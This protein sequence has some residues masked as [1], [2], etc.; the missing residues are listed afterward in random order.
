MKKVA[1]T[2]IGCRLN[3]YE[4]E[5]LAHQLTSIGLARV[6]FESGA[7]L[8]IINTCTVT[9][10]ADA[11]CRRAIARAGKYG[12]AKVV[13]VGCYVTADPDKVAALNGV[14]LVIGN[15]DKDRIPELLQQFFPDLFE[16]RPILDDQHFISDF[17]HHNRAWV[18]IGDGCNQNCSFCIVPKVRGSLINRLPDEIISEINSLVEAGYEEVVLTGVHIGQYQHDGVK[19]LG[20]LMGLVLSNTALPRL[21]LSSIEPQEV[22]QPLIQAMLAGGIRVCRHLHIPLQS[23]SD[24][25][26]KMMRRPYNLEKYLEIVRNIR[27]SI[28]NIVIGADVIV[29]FPGESEDDF[30]QTISV[31]QSGLIDYLHV[32]S[33]SDRDGTDASRLPG[34]IHNDVIKHRNKILRDI[35]SKCSAEALKREIGQIAYV[36]SEH[37]ADSGEH[38]WGITDNYLKAAIP[39]EK[40][41]TRKILRMHVL[42]AEVDYLIGEVY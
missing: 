17:Y 12:E 25:I 16:S 19:S 29:G 22:N 35:S 9:G 5:R 2:T 36:I 11:S 4:T 3:Q 33:Y 42:T 28:N 26:L 34:K 40:G 6:D 20:E 23:G 30:R 14:D 15:D 32:F 8:Y 27:K 39:K 41:G 37:K 38:C 24:S 10:R 7:D 31:A 21:R 13:V 18:K 1:L